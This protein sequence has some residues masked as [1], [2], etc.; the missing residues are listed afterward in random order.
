MF[1]NQEEVDVKYGNQEKE[2]P[3]SAIDSTARGGG[4]TTDQQNELRRMDQLTLDQNPFFSFY[5]NDVETPITVGC[6][7]L[8]NGGFTPT[9]EL[10]GEVPLRNGFVTGFTVITS[11]TLDAATGLQFRLFRNGVA[12]NVSFQITNHDNVVNPS[13][14]AGGAVRARGLSSSAG[15]I[16]YV[17]N[18]YIKK[19][20]F[21]SSEKLALATEAIQLPGYTDAANVGELAV[22]LYYN[23]ASM[24][25]EEMASQKYGGGVLDGVPGGGSGGGGGGSGGGVG[26]GGGG[27]GI[28]T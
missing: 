19:F 4:F 28:I 22:K 11:G 6:Y 5:W 7:L 20:H 21:K 16:I 3:D 17:D 27:G 8:L 1:N 10:F 9:V 13:G 2:V 12:S 15:D 14:N 24:T 18:E 26:G 23:F 25:A